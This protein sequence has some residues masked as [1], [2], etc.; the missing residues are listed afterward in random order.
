MT[1][2][3][4]AV[5]AVLA[6]LTALL[7]D[8]QGSDDSLSFR[9]WVVIVLAA[10]VVG[11]TTYL[12]PNRPSRGQ[13][14]ASNVAVALMVVGVVLILADLLFAQV[15]FGVGLGVLLLIGGIVLAVLERR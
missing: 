3:K 6:G 7:T 10:L 14:G 15:W 13:A 2:N 11:A 5:A 8:L 9:D 4:A 1:A 12:V